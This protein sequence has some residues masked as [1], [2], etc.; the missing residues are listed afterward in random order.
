MLEWKTMG[1]GMI[2]PTL[3]M[4]FFIAWKTRKDPDFYINVAVCCWI[5]ANAY[6]M[7]CEF[8]GFAHLKDMAGIPFVLGMVSV[9]FFYLR[10]P[11]VTTES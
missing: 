4:A 7:C 11:P 6:W 9:A 10:K 5:L 8:F 2:P 1:V 3:F